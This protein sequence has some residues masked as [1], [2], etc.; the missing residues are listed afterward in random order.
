MLN[1]IYGGKLS[2]I[3]TQSFCRE[4][5]FDSA[6]TLV[7]RIKPYP[8]LKLVGQFHDELN[9]EW[10]PSEEPNAL[11]LDQA[12]HIVESAM[13]QTPVPGFPLAADVKSA[14]RYIK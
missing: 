12:I 2:G 1:T 10:V 11:E 6:A 5:F 8:N 14:Y 7:G 3:L 13:S 4:M 9:V